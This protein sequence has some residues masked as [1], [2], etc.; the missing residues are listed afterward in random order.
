MEFD[1]IIIGGGPAGIAAYIYAS[2]SN[3]K[4][5]LIEKSFLGGKLVNISLIEN[6]PGFKSISG[7]DLATNLAQGINNVVYEEVISVKS[8]DKFTVQTNLNLYT[9]KYLICASGSHNKEFTIAQKY[10]G[11]GLSYCAVCDGP[12][13]KNRDVMVVGGNAS[14]IKEAYFLSQ[15]C[16]EV[17]L[18]HRRFDFRVNEFELSK[19]KNTPNIHVLTPYEVIKVSGDTVINSVVIQNNQTKE[20]KT[21]EVSGLFPYIG[22]FSNNEYLQNILTDFSVNKNFESVVYKNLYLVGDIL[23]QEH[24]Q[25]VIAQSQGVVAVLDILN[26]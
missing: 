25:I 23:M 24:Q 10:F 2:R 4:V 11:K 18:V 1:L 22:S 5:L 9:C 7:F 20:E 6:Y 13:F 19:I 26:S 16:Q 17:Y 8:T 21:I 15:I 14:A 12:L 3:L